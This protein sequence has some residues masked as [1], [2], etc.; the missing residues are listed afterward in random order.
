MDRASGSNAPNSLPLLVTGISGYVGWHLA[1]RAG[2][3][4]RLV[5]TYL[6]RMPPGGLEA[7]RL[8]VRDAGAVRALVEAVRPRAVIH[9]AYRQDEPEVNVAGTRHVAT[10]CEAVGARCV[11]VSTDM[12]FDGQQGWYRE[13]DAP[14]PLGPY[15][16][17]KVAA[18]REVLSRGGI[19]ARTA[20]VFGFDPLDPITDRLVVR[21]LRRGEPASLFVDELRTPTYAPDL[22]DA[23]LELADLDP[24]DASRAGFHGLL[25]LSGP[26]RLSRY[27]L[28]LK[29]ARAFGLDPSDLRPTRREQSGLARPP[30][31]S[32]DTSLARRTLRT[33][34]RSVDEALITR[35]R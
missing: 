13:T 9:A 8:E 30:D 27:E 35:E 10:A 12:V 33:R 34:I 5:G 2:A 4:R 7:H 19:V 29:L 24:A 18:E 1:A 11:L 28:G 15:G 22:A 25:H 21:P 26:Q 17:S 16:A 23:L 31:C 14:N 6:G 20:L 3:R 32:L